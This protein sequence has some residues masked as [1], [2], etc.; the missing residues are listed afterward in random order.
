MIDPLKFTDLKQELG[1]TTL[2]AVTKGRDQE[3]VEK[4]YSLGQR[5]FGENRV[6]EL[7]LKAAGLGGRGLKEIRWHFIGQLQSNK[8]NKLLAVENLHAIHS[9]GSIKLLKELKKREEKCQ[10][11]VNI[12]LQVNISEEQQKNGFMSFE[13]L[14]EACHFFRQLDC[15]KIMLEGLMGMGAA[16]VSNEE[17]EGYFRKLNDYRLKIDPNLKLSMGMS[18]DYKVALRFH[19]DYVR[20]GRL[21]F[22]EI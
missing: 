16:S 19:T 20:I 8:V 9:V 10:G 13:K 12:F 6:D 2:V 18:G 14:Q 11:P 7:A 15:K 1:K 17:E 4:L 21:L 3:A 22:K 5:D